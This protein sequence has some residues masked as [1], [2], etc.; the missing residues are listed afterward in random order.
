MRHGPVV[1]WSVVAVGAVVLTSPVFA[2][3]LFEA[4]SESSARPVEESRV[5]ENP[6]ASVVMQPV[7]KFSRG[8]INLMTGVLEIPRTIGETQQ[9]K[10][11]RQGWTRGVVEGIRRAG[12]RTGAGVVDLVTFPAPPYHHLYL[13]PELIVGET[14]LYR[15]LPAHMQWE[16]I[17]PPGPPLPQGP[18][19]APITVLTAPLRPPE[20]P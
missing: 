15:G 19:A 18:V 4:L 14:G 6:Y 20:S 2:A 17:E 9:A 12:I 10:G 8:L 16:A 13:R 3:S 5:R 11:W 1:C 7:D